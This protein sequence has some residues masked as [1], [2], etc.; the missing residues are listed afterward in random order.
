MRSGF[1]KNIFCL[2]VATI[3]VSAGILLPS[4]QASALEPYDQ[5]KVERVLSNAAASLQEFTRNKEYSPWDTI[6]LGTA[7]YAVPPGLV[8]YYKQLSPK[9][10]TTAYAAT[11]M[12]MY[13]EQGPDDQKVQELAERLAQAQKGSGKFADQINGEGEDLIN[14]H[15]WAVIALK[16]TGSSLPETE[17][18]YS[19]LVEQQNTDGGY[20]YAVGLPDS[21]VDMTAMALMAFA[22]LGK[23]EK[24]ANVQ[25]ALQYLQTQQ[26]QE[27]G[28]FGSWGVET[29]TDSCAIVIQAL[30]AQEQDPT[31][32]QWTTRGGN[33]VRALLSL[34][35]QDG[36][37]PYTR[38]MAANQMSTRQ[39]LL[40]LNDL[41]QLRLGEGH[42]DTIPEQSDF[43]D[44]SSELWGYAEIALLAQ[45]GVMSGYPDG[46]FKPQQSLSR[47]EFAVIVARLLEEDHPVRNNPYFSDVPVEH[48]AYEAV[49]SIAASNIV[50]GYGGNLYGPTNKATIAEVAAV[51]L[52]I[53]GAEE[54]PQTTPWWAGVNE[55]AMQREL[56]F[57]NDVPEQPATR[58]ETAWIMAQL[59]Q[60]SR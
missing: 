7:G 6:A 26:S 36:S 32:E 40:A 41:H 9:D 20:A 37:F 38:G 2:L 21:D 4:T 19:W 30:V 29:T 8:D 10:P 54:P 33:P 58:A 22:A 57:E 44:I 18:A 27:T 16:A 46:T 45:E 15:I 55:L 39:A 59:I 11:L 1:P 50:R 53:S 51:A 42:R 49:Q 35:K 31:G 24:D 48:W 43:K 52:R 14:A 25:K 12:A 56:V 23:D 47:A 3:F 13:W 5:T 60:L 28:G 34:Q 17:S